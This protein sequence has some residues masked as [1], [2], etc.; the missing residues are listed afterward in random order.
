V[1]DLIAV[2]Y[3]A[4]A[5]FHR[6]LQGLQAWS[7]PPASI[8]VVD[9]SASEGTADELRRAVGD[10]VS[11]VECAGNPG[12]GAAMNVGLK[13]K[14]ASDPPYVLLVTQ[15]VVFSEQ[16]VAALIAYL[17]ADERAAIAAPL[18]TYASDPSR[19]FSA[20]GLLDSQAQTSHAGSG[21]NCR[22]WTDLPP[23]EIA[24]A[25]GAA[26]LIR[27]TALKHVGG[28][29]ERYFL[30]FEEIELQL[31]MRLAGWSIRMVPGA[32]CSQEPGNFRPYLRLRN[33]A[34][35]QR[36]F[37]ALFDQ[38]PR[39]LFW[40]VLRVSLLGLKQRRWGTLLEVAHALRDVGLGH[41]G[42]PS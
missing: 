25:D 15:D 38:R 20:G 13:S 35:L 5:A 7:C 8:T 41:Y 18:L 3:H 29:D 2:H 9:N 4:P 12:Y 28:F 23:Y 17:Q 36:S 34:L 22:V 32:V 10:R 39:V 24:W 26:L 42:K 40:D 1:F 14:L 6:T 31:R 11:V 27:K 37:P 30:Y 19:V 21:T 33:R 16:A